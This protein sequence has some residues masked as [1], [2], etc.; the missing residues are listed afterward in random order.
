MLKYKKHEEGAQQH[1]NAS[2]AAQLKA[3]YIAAWETI[4]NEK[5]HT[6]MPPQNIVF[7]LGGVLLD[8]SEQRMLD[9]FFGGLPQADRDQAA[10]A[11]F[12]SGLWRR[13]DRGDFD[14]TGMVNEVCALLPER[15]HGRVADMFPHTFEAMTPLP[16]CALIPRLKARGQRV[17]LLSNSPYAFHREKFRIPHID[18]F[19]GVFVS[20]D[21]HALKPDPEIYRLF[22]EKFGLRAEDCLFIDDMPENIAG[23][24]AAGMHGHC[25]AAR[26]CGELSKALGI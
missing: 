19:D 18:Q 6:A 16:A 14:E 10:A 1:P 11:L 4:K 15:L 22:L 12:R 23:A 17:Y 26:D 21:V 9:V 7:D 2:V 13:M 24:Q 5:E 25:F 8:F 20:C 3:F